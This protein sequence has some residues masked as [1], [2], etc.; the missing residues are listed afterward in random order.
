MGM[1]TGWVYKVTLKVMH[2]QGHAQ[3]YVEEMATMMLSIY[4]S[5]VLNI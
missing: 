2:E 3:V 5:D 4:N 1:Y